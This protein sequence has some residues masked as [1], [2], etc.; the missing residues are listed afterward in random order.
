MGAGNG[1]L[2]NANVGQVK[3]RFKGLRFLIL[4]LSIFTGYPKIQNVLVA[5]K[6]I[7]Y[8]VVRILRQ[9]TNLP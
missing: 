6:L 3:H 8:Q 7:K 5:K 4:H 2:S 9:I 1:K